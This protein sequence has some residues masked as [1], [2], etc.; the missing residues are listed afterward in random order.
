VL[1]GEAGAGKTT[2]WRAGVVAARESGARVL[3]ARPVGE[4]MR[5]SFAA[6]GD[7]LHDVLPGADEALPEPQRRALRA[8]LALEEPAEVRPL[9]L[10]V[11]VAGTL[12]ALAAEDPV[13]VAIDDLQWL[14]AASA[15][16][17]GFALRRLEQEP[18]RL[19]GVRRL[20]A[21]GGR[22]VLRLEHETTMPVGPLS[23]GAVQ[24]LLANALDL[25]LP[26]STLVRLY[27]ASGG[28]PFFALELARAL[29]RRGGRFEAGGGV[30]VPPSLSGLLRE[31]LDGV[32]E[33]TRQVLLAA[34]LLAQPTVDLLVAAVGE[35][36]WMELRPA[37]TAGIVELD[38]ERLV[39]SHPLLAAVLV[40]GLEPTMRRALHARLAALLPEGEERARH[41]AAAAGGPDAAAAGALEQAGMVAHQRGAVD[42]AAELLERAATLAV[43]DDEGA[44]LTIA[45]AGAYTVAEDAAYADQLLHRLLPELPPGRRR[46]E[47]L[48]GLIQ[49]EVETAALPALAKDALAEVGE[50]PQ[51]R[52]AIL[53]SLAEW[54]EI[55]AG[56]GAARTRARAGLQL[57][58]QADDQALLLRALAYVGH[59]E[60]LGRGDLW[61]ELL[62]RA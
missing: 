33:E 3:E 40:E 12:A 32:P 37:V 6:L 28:N 44:R 62:E 46:G 26:R 5:L 38:G 52:A 19:L 51:L 17:L 20:E 53:L 58:E 31:R 14:D 2:V 57:A 30:P 50:D 15:G 22:G 34:A 39:F 16:V 25:R 36:A 13:V 8:A 27:D 29:V 48:L 11:A 23:L 24:R 59:L 56:I 60:T 43:E 35:G 4:E 7:L 54:E 42:V 45:A 10:G 18:V 21:S 61:Q 1:E 55:T 49:A 41:L 47:A 9:P